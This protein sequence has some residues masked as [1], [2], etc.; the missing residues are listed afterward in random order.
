MSYANRFLETRAYRAARETGQIS[1]PE[2]ATDP[3]RSLFQRV[4]SI[5]SPKFGDNANV[6]LVKLG[7][8]FIAMT[9]TP[10]P[11]QFDPQ[12]L[13]AAGVAYEPPGQLTTAH[14]HMDRASKGM[15]NYAAKLGPRS[16]YKFFL[17]RPDSDSPEVLGSLPVRSPR[18]CT[19][20][21]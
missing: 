19:P 15:L 13:A 1:Y 14:P 8:R 12:T 18:T 3:C 9:E 7:Q 4:S 20:S 17:L 21:A 6:N 16:S 2:F 10:I 11:V 5:F